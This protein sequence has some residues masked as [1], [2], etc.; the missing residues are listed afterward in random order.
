MRII[1]FFSQK[2]GCGKTTACVNLSVA[3]AAL[4]RR[5]LVIDLDSNACAS[6]T[7]GV[8]VG[9][10]HS[11]A[12][13]LLG[14]QPLLALIRPS[15]AEGVWLAPGAPDLHTVEQV[16]GVQDPRRAD[17]AGRLA[18]TALALE[19]HQLAPD[20]FDYVLLD[21][22]GG[23]P[24]MEHLAL[25]ACDE[26]IVPTGLSLYD[27]YA[28][29]P[30]LQLVVHARH[31]RG[32]GRPEFLGFLPNGA[33]KVGVPRK[34]RGK[35]DEHRLPSFTPIRHSGL[36]RTLPGRPNVNER[37]VVLARPDSAVAASFRQVAAEIDLGI[38]AAREAMPPTSPELLKND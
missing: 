9:L 7:F 22:P 34:L 29:T 12:A 4:G 2:G 10:E 16:D 21:C 20:A 23:H 28:A 3:L 1:A 14:L 17:E 30:T 36:L 27:L 35:L 33:G 19:L 32:N 31:A 11:V 25:L 24:F 5:V 26:I 18:P 38:D 6:Q 37:L 15:G 13:A 8:V